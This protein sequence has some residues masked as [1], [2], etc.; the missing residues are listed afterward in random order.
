MVGARCTLY[1]N[2]PIQLLKTA[3][4][5]SIKEGE[6]V[7]GT[8]TGTGAQGRALPLLVCAK[9]LLVVCFPLSGRV[10][11]LRRREAFPRQAGHQRH[12]RVS[13]SHA[14]AHSTR[15]RATAL[16]FDP[17]FCVCAC[18]RVCGD[19]Q[20]QPRARV[21]NLSEESQQSGAADVRRLAHDPRHDPHCCH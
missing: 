8:G 15:F 3:A 12:E 9:K 10:V 16:L 20:V 13:A 11:W 5:Q 21:R 18:V 4:A 6:V 17:V 19:A 1:N 14:H 2:Q 7:G